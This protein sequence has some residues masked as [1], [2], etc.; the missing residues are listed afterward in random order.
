MLVGRT[1]WPSR[2]VRPLARAI[3]VSSGWL[4]VTMSAVMPRPVGPTTD[5]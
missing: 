4:K 5:A 3:G 2:D 1:V